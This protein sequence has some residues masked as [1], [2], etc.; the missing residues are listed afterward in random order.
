MEKLEDRGYIVNIFWLAAFRQTTFDNLTW[1]VSCH[2][3]IKAWKSIVWS[4]GGNSIT[5]IEFMSSSYHF[6]LNTIACCFFL[7]YFMVCFQLLFFCDTVSHWY[8]L[9][10]CARYS[11]LTFWKR[12][13]PWVLR[14]P[15]QSCAWQQIRRSCCAERESD[16][17]EF[18]VWGGCKYGNGVEKQQAGSFWWSDLRGWCGL[19]LIFLGFFGWFVMLW[20]N[21]SR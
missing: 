1:V 5:C 4:I 14:M 19:L 3:Y 2:F 15:W 20:F 6:G 18:L 12:P 21:H 9:C 16:F 7:W 10:W 8:S 13:L 17:H 11:N